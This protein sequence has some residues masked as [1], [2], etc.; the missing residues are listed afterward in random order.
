M[1]TNSGWV[2]PP[3]ASDKD[4][5]TKEDQVKA[6]RKLARTAEA[7]YLHLLVTFQYGAEGTGALP[8]TESFSLVPPE[9]K[10]KLELKKKEELKKKKDEEAIRKQD[11]ASRAKD[12]Y[13]PSRYKSTYKPRSEAGFHPYAG[14]NSGSGY[15]SYPRAGYTS[16]PGAGFNHYSGAGNGP[17]TT[18]LPF[19]PYNSVPGL[20]LQ[21]PGLQGGWLAHP[22][23]G[24]SQQYASP[25]GFNGAATFSPGGASMFKP[26]PWYSGPPPLHQGQ[27]SYNSRDL[28][29][30][31]KNSKCGRCDIYGHWHGDNKCK[32]EDVERKLAKLSLRD[33]QYHAE[34]A[35]LR[36]TQHH[37][38]AQDQGN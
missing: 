7:D 14:T 19:S 8:E 22:Q 5:K 29:E 26:S 17:S 34:A 30:R 25:Q 16:H 24:F 13:G 21:A 31:K 10:K 38:E 33:S 18:S 32:P 3:T 4:K 11:L 35:A 20:S 12:T 37:P 9:I 27:N 23:D 15:T 1:A 2:L 36:L 6:L 28:Q